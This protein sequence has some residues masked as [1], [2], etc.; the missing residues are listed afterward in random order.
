LEDDHEGIC[1]KTPPKKSLFGRTKP[2]RES[3]SENGR[4]SGLLRSCAAVGAPPVPKWKQKQNQSTGNPAQCFAL[5]L[6]A[7]ISDSAL[8]EEAGF[9][10]YLPEG[11]VK[12]VCLDAESG[13]VAVACGREKDTRVEIVDL[14]VASGEAAEELKSPRESKLTGLAARLF[15]ADPGVPCVGT[16]SSSQ[17]GGSA[18]TRLVLDLGYDKIEDRWGEGV[19]ETGGVAFASCV[20]LLR[21][22]DWTE[23]CVD[24]NFGELPVVRESEKSDDGEASGDAAPRAIAPAVA[25][26]SL[27]D[28]LLAVVLFPKAPE[29]VELW[30]T[31]STLLLFRLSPDLSAVVCRL[32]KL[33]LRAHG[34]HG[35]VPDLRLQFSE[36]G[37]VEALLLRNDMGFDLI[38]F[39]RR[40]LIEERHRYPLPTDDWHCHCLRH[41]G[42]WTTLV[43]AVGV[44]GTQRPLDE[45]FSTDLSSEAYRAEWVELARSASASKESRMAED[46]VAGQW[47]GERT[48]ILGSA[49]LDDLILFNLDSVNTP[50]GDLATNEHEQASLTSVSAVAGDSAFRSMIPESTVVRVPALRKFADSRVRPVRRNFR[51]RAPVKRVTSVE[52]D[53]VRGRLLVNIGGFS[54]AML[55]VFCVDDSTGMVKSAK[56]V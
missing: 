37:G 56:K 38:R 10:D 7:N 16:A 36:S 43:T 54:H 53:P 52:V 13:C 27:D 24:V 35:P 6:N 3:M 17:S 9:P 8:G 11:D 21:G 12:G 20:S 23:F 28:V 46:A 40:A 32:Q 39:D 18:A 45:T 44:F 14:D 55:L 5:A 1:F 31:Y 50:D 48:L 22:C 25:L 29:N 33:K 4:I 26:P 41:C 30:E 19:A 42:E 15:V 49:P 47:L 51:G 2:L 34:I